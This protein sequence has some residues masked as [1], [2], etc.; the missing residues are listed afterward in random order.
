MKTC[1]KCQAT[2]P[3]TEFFPDR[4]G[5]GDGYRNRCKA[6]YPMTGGKPTPIQRA[7]ARR[8]RGE[9]NAEYRAHAQIQADAIKRAKLREAERQWHAMNRAMIRAAKKRRSCHREWFATLTPDQQAAYRRAA[10]KEAKARYWA[11]P[12]AHRDKQKRF[13]ANNPD[14]VA[15]QRAIRQARTEAACDGTLTK[16]VL[17]G[18][19]TSAK[20]CPYCDKPIRRKTLDHVIPLSRGGMHSISNVLVACWWCNVTKGAMLPLDYVWHLAG[21]HVAQA[22]PCA[23]SN[24]HAT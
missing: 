23:A 13:K 22:E 9:T 16:D 8:A 19:Y 5:Y 14:K 12:Q 7:M 24:V 4:R 1:S 18:L 21:M 20:V 10:A 15:K 17:V 2:K 3:L 11:S 6:C